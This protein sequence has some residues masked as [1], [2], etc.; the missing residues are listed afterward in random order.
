VVALGALVVG[1][2]VV[3][4]T[5]SRALPQVRSAVAR[6]VRDMSE[7][8]GLSGPSRLPATPAPLP[9]PGTSPPPEVTPTPSA[10][11]GSAPPRA[12]LA[13]PPAAATAWVRPSA[14]DCRWGEVTLAEDQ[15]LDTEAET[16]YS[17]DAAWYRQTAGWW[18]QAIR[19]LEGICGDGLTTVAGAPAGT[20]A[21]EPTHA[22][23][24]A[25]VSHLA[26]AYGIH[27]SRVAAATDPTLTWDQDWVANYGRLLW[28]WTMS[29]CDVWNGDS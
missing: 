8:L 5:V 29:G 16:W 26:T 14:A 17:A 2:V 25:D 3:Y 9:T 27:A 19:D 12:P 22:A 4:P 28:I 13:S 6:D 21:P 15:T 10:S 18:Y 11:S 20:M 23:C 1:A 24:V 7:A